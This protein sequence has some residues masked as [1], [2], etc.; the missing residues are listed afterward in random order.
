MIRILFSCVIVASQ[1]LSVSYA[2]E[3]DVKNVFVSIIPQK[4][5]IER[6]AGDHIDVSVMVGA[7]QSPETYE[8]SPRQMALLNKSSLYFQIGV[9][10]E[11]IWIDAIKELNPNMKIIACCEELKSIALTGHLHDGH[12]QAGN[13]PDPHIWT[14]PANAKYIALKMKNALQD[15]FP[16]YQTEFEDNYIKLINDLDKLDADIR[17]LLSGLNNR[18]FIVAHPSWAYYARA[19][20]L[21]QLPIELNG[22][23]VRAKSLSKLIDIA[24]SQNI[25]RVFVQKQFNNNSAEILAKEIDADIVELDPLADDYI[26]NLYYVTNAIASA[27]R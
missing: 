24:I 8:P 14:S 12:V 2:S 3:N 20:N 1:F 7:G 22:K 19:Y 15:T 21:V 9:P 4:Y 11:N 27:W 5:F 18:H 13:A 16:V 6:I 25:K 10:F 26:A 17:S 23:E